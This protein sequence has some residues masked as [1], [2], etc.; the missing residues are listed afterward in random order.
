MNKEI[1]LLNY[2]KTQIT[3]NQKELEALKQAVQ[4]KELLIEVLLEQSKNLEL[5]TSIARSLPKDISEQQ[6]LEVFHISQDS[7]GMLI[8]DI[9]GAINIK[10]GKDAPSHRIVEKTIESLFRQKKVEQ[11]N[12]G[13]MRNRRFKTA[14]KQAGISA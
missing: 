4:E 3:V 5:K 8:K 6:V 2:T 11:V 12:V 1:V 10:F 9:V 7:K 13:A 14:E